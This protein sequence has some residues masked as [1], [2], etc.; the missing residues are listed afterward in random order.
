MLVNFVIA[1]LV[2]IIVFSIRYSLWKGDVPTK[3]S[4][5]RWLIS[6]IITIVL[7]FIGSAIDYSRNPNNSLSGSTPIYLILCI[8]I[9]NVLESTKKSKEK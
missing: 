6:I 4:Q 1:G 7:L 2:T 9:A 5:N 3:I 8:T